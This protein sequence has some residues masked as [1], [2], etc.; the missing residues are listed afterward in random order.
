M[1]LEGNC[2]TTAMG[3]MRDHS[4]KILPKEAIDSKKG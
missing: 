4:R 2:R 3:I 1:K